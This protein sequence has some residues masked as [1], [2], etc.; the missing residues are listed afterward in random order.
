MFDVSQVRDLPECGSAAPQLI[1]VDAFWDIVF[2]WQPGQE[3]LRRVSVPMSL[4][5]DV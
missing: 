3:G 1:G 4:E 2:S 5:E